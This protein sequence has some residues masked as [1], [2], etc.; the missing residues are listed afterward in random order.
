MR[1]EVP[2]FDAR[3]RRGIDEEAALAFRR[4]GLLVVRH[5]I[6]PA[7]L[8]ALRG[9]TLALV[10]RAASQ[11]V[12]DHDYQYK[13]HEESGDE[14]PFRIEYVVDKTASCKALL[15]HPFVL[16]SVERLQ[17]RDFIPTWDSMV[18]K[19]AGAGAAIDWH[20]DADRSK[21]D[22]ARP[23][24][25]VD[26][27]LDGSDATNCLWG[28]PGSNLWNDA[29]ATAACAR[30][31]AGGFGR[32][33]GVP[34]L[35]HA[36][37]ALFHDILVLHGSPAC[38]SD[39]RRVIYFEFRPAELEL[40]V[41]PHTPDYVPLKQRVLQA[42]LR[43]RAHASYAAGEEPFEYAPATS[44]AAT[45]LAGDETLRSYRHPHHEHWRWK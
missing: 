7:E 38:R 40:R 23:I 6:E 22:P 15:A 41:G 4:T 10:E 9:E 37:D 32:D 44:L 2:E 21:C 26:F 14:V 34:I 39:L 17:G 43:D 24:F 19:L 31:S 13:K 25:N 5:L 45:A 42:C 35:M 16:R 20:R 8:A 33:G 28:I 29:E 12:E 30:L 11:R 36:G 18:F 3:G 1:A 27:Y